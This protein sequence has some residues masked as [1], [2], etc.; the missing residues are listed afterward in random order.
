LSAPETSEILQKVADEGKTAVSHLTPDQEELFLYL[1]QDRDVLGKTL[2]EG[3][4]FHRERPPTKL[5]WDLRQL[6]SIG[7]ARPAEGWRWQDNVHA[8]ITPFGDLALKILFDGRPYKAAYLEQ[9]LSERARHQS[10]DAP[11]HD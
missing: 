8:A 7:L 2:G 10:S 9:Y 5:H 1:A 4:Q 11:E 3:L 6:R